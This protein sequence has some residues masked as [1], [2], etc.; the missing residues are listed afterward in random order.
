MDKFRNLEES[1]PKL[2]IWSN[3]DLM[4]YFYF[5]ILISFLLSKNIISG[6][7]LSPIFGVILFLF[8]PGY[9]LSR[10]LNERFTVDVIGYSFLMG[11]CIQITCVGFYDLLSIILKTDFQYFLIISTTSSILA[12][13]IISYKL[14]IHH[15]LSYIK[16]EFCKSG[17]NPLIYIFIFIIITHFIYASFNSSSFLPDASLYFDVARTLVSHGTFG[18]HV[19]ND[20]LSPYDPYF[21]TNGFL[22]HKAI[23]YVFAIFFYVQDVSLKAAQFAIWFGSSLLIYPVY[24]I[25]QKLFNRKVAIVASVLISVH[26]LFLYYSAIPYG[27]EIFGIV[28][29]LTATY[30]IMEG[31]ERRSYLL[32]IVAGILLGIANNMWWALFYMILPIL[33]IVFFVFDKNQVNKSKKIAGLFSSTALLFLYAFVLK[34]F[35]L[36]FIWLPVVLIEIIILIISIKYKTRLLSYTQSLVIAIIFATSLPIMKEYLFPKQITAVMQH[37]VNSGVAPSVFHAFTLY[38]KSLSLNELI[39]YYNYASYHLTFI[40]L[41]LFLLYF[42]NSRKLKEKLILGGIFLVNLVLVALTYYSTY[43][44]NLYSAGRYLLL[45]T[46]VAIIGVSYFTV[47]ITSQIILICDLEHKYQSF[48]KVKIN[49]LLNIAGISIVCLI[50]ITF[51]IPQY[52][53]G[54]VNIKQQDPLVKYGWSDKLLTWIK[55]NTTKN[56]VLLS[57]RA[58]EL[59]W[60]TDRNIVNVRYQNLNLNETSIKELNLLIENFNAKYIVVDQYFDWSF[61][62]LRYFYTLPLDSSVLLLPDKM[63]GI[64]SSTNDSLYGYQSVFSDKTSNGTTTIWKIINS[65]DIQ[66]RLIYQGVEFD[67]KLMAGNEGNI[68]AENDSGKLV[69]GK[70]NSYAYS[71]VKDSS[72]L[73]ASTQNHGINFIAWKI[74]DMNGIK[75]NRIEIW[76][77]NQ[78][79]LNL[80]PP[81]KIGIWASNLNMDEIDDIRIVISGQPNGY[82]TMN[83]LALGN[84]QN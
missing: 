49:N 28:F 52:S 38:F 9:Y 24:S 67:K 74:K 56:D 58:R 84:I 14:K 45:P 63:T 80:N 62:K 35:S 21:V 77:H 44:D 41:F 29:L 15:D 71:F 64:S 72:S 79:V 81:T 69:I 68:L 82:L 42:I 53:L 60:F 33:P 70:N 13:K 7:L 18:S 48:K 37:A 19:I 78:N 76:S 20:E 66:Y 3:N 73:Q 25:T 23:T 11:L 4:P 6:N 17:K 83:W 10:I 36:V 65:S 8:I 5:I 75:I 57:D 43:P 1:L 51:F 40:I 50:I 32:L 12:L 47:S 16:A 31:I 59:A 34:I 55:N 61:P 26:P 54:I 39:N 30:F 22:E 27:P 46:L 2:S